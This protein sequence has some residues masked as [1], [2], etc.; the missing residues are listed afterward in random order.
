MAINPMSQ[1]F[2]LSYLTTAP[3]DAREALHLARK[4]GYYAIGVRLAP[5]TPGGHFSPLSE[6]A[7]LLRETKACIQD[8]GVAVFDIE[9]VRLDEQFVPDSFDRQLEVAA[10]L[11]AKVISVIGDDP[12]GQRLIDSFAHFCDSAASYSLAVAAEF[13]PYSRVP[14]SNAALRILQQARRSNARIVVDLLHVHRSNTTGADLA[15]IPQEW[16][17]YAQLCDAPAEVPTT[18]EGLVHTARYARLLPGTG[19]IDIRGMV[20]YLPASLPFSVEVPNTEQLALHGA[21][22]WARRALLATRR[23]L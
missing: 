1:Q 20:R 16:L 12:D 3:L 7:A 15:A 10:E 14:D 5:L 23:A 2:T 13:M 21:E 9:G 17:G 19:G 4:V 18:R 6:D 8:T 11:G 22:E